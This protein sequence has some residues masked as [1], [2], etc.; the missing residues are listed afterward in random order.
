MLPLLL[1]GLVRLAAAE[2]VAASTPVIETARWSGPLPGAAGLDVDNPRGDLRLRGADGDQV[3]LVA[4]LQRLGP[5]ERRARLDVAPDGDRLV[6]RVLVPDGERLRLEDRVDLVLLLPRRAAVTAR[7]GFGRLEARGLTG[8]LEAS[9]SSGALALDLAGPARARSISGAIEAQVDRAALA[10]G[11]ELASG[12]GGVRVEL[13]RDAEGEIEIRSRD[14]ILFDLALPFRRQSAPSGA[15]PVRGRIGRGGG[16][17]AV[18]AGGEI[19][20]LWAR[21]GAAP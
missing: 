17:L 20:L 8:R 11:V 3:E 7:V 4:E 1:A 18:E 13:A 6:V 2:P 12:A 14:R 16:R 10:A 9:S 15:P 5:P 21:A 19:Q